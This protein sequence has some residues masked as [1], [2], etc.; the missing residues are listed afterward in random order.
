VTVK[1][2]ALVVLP[3]RERVALPCPDLPELVIGV[4][5]AVTVGRGWRD[6]M[7]GHACLYAPTSALS[8]VQGVGRPGCALA[9]CSGA[10]LIGPPPGPVPLT[11]AGVLAAA[12]EKL[13][14]REEQ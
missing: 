12:P 1:E 7:C 13:G 6:G 14:G 11:F 10:R 9:A 4:C 2:H 3:S 8:A 5:D